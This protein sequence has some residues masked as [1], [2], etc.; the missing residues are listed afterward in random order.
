[1]LKY[2]VYGLVRQWAVLF[3]FNLDHICHWFI[4]SLSSGFRDCVC[5]GQTEGEVYRQ[6]KKHSGSGDSCK[7]SLSN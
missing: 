2:F 7:Y 4:C 5:S 1:M 6:S 3:M